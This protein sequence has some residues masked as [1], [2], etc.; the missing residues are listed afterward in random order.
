MTYYLIYKITNLVNG[1]MYIGK[2]QTDYIDDGYMGSGKI[3]KRAVSKY[4][5]DCFRKEYLM[6]CESKEEMDYMERVFVDQTWISRADTYNIKIGGEGGSCKGINKGKSHPSW[7]KGKKMSAEYRRA[8]SNGTK[9]AM[10]RLPPEARAKLANRKGTTPWN[11]GKTTP[12]EVRALKYKP[13]AQYTE[14]G[15]LVK[16]YSSA[17]DA[18]TSTG[19][20]RSS[21]CYCLKGRYK[22][23]GGYR[24]RYA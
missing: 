23:A 17:K 3:L 12:E 7:F 22:T 6:S 19:I 16:R 1:K 24:W 11:K 18:S 20:C 2:H 9:K 14:D 10:S 4:G 13:V 21:I 8:V 15:E 5:I